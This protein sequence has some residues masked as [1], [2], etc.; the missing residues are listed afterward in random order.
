MGLCSCFCSCDPFFFKLWS[1]MRLWKIL[2][3]GILGWPSWLEINGLKSSL[4][5]SLLREA[6][7][8]ATMFYLILP[9]Q[10]PIFHSVSFFFLFF[11]LLLWD[12]ILCF[13]FWCSPSGFIIFCHMGVFSWVDWWV[14]LRLQIDEH[15]QRE[16]MNHRSLKHPNIVRFKEVLLVNPLSYKC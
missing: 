15:V 16:I 12:S 7:R 6:K 10:F 13:L 1:V 8:S 11:C 9:P 14:P 5:S 3:L 4:L 2:G